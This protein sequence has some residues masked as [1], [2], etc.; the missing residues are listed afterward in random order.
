M[1]AGSCVLFGGMLA[2]ALP[3][4]AKTP[5][6]IFEVASPSIVVVEVHDSAGKL[7]ATGSGVVIATGEV[8]TNCHVA[9]EGKTLL[10]RQGKASY[11]A[12]VHYADRER[13]L[14]QLTVPNFKASPIALGDVANLRTGARV[15]AIGAPEGLELSVSEGLISSLRELGAG[16]TII[17]T[18]A[19]ISPG[20]SGG[21]LFDEEGRL[22]GITTFYLAEG[23]N[24]N[25]ALP[26][27]WVAQL[28][29]R[30]G[31]Q[32]GAM[33]TSLDWLRVAVALEQKKDWPALAACAQRWIHAEPQNPLAW[34]SLA[35]S[36]FSLSQYAQAIEAQREA[37]R[38]DP[39]SA[40]D[41]ENL[42]NAY[43]EIHQYAQA[44]EAERE[45]LRIDPND[46][47]AWFLLGNAYDSLHQPAQEI[48]AYR[49]AVR[50]DPKLWN[51]WFLL[52]HTYYQLQQYDQSVEAFR[53]ALR[54]N[55]K[56]AVTWQQLGASYLFNKQ[57]A[58]AIEAF[59]ESLRIEPKRALT[60]YSLGGAYA[61]LAQSP[62]AIELAQ[63]IEAY[64]EALR[65]DPKYAN[66]WLNL[67]LAYGM[68]GNRNGAI[69]AYQTLRALDPALADKLFNLAI[70]PR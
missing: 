52:G 28:P 14:C 26:V 33:K 10:V 39:N 7:E 5:Q 42:G 62:Q 61:Q 32:A 41:W 37:L 6:Q 49:E 21:G 63:A 53:E 47:K 58:Q 45:A 70:A 67:G 24:L 17:Q 23:Q 20:S 11:P 48:E 18:T 25:F 27:N 66:A 55:P 31:A 68:Q 40:K 64:R 51:A 69:E 60:W 50:I 29:H 4:L 65:I 57:P 54:I 34:S 43:I 44:V 3:A 35:E 8:V 12:H 16:S 2:A 36:R 15:V 30:N 13:D 1:Y 19:P 46:A 38:I 9:Q 59:H 22:I 56:S